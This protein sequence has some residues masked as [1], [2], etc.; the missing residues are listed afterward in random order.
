ML[1]DMMWR[2]PTRGRL[3]PAPKS[4]DVLRQIHGMARLPAK[5]A[6]CYD[7]KAAG[8]IGTHNRCHNPLPAFRIH[9]RL[10]LDCGKAPSTDEER[11]ASEQV[12]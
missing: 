11:K 10:F 7:F 1:P 6:H 2:K 4:S 5:A 8:I 12:A 9:R 3:W